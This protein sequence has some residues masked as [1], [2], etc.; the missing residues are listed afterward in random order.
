MKR[1]NVALRGV[2][3]TNTEKQPGRQESDQPEVMQQLATR[4]NSRDSVISSISV[5]STKHTEYT[6]RMEQW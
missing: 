6:E 5:L 2:S 3:V 4:Y 1:D